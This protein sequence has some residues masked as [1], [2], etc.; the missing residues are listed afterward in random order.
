MAWVSWWGPHGYFDIILA[1]GVEFVKGKGLLTIMGLVPSCLCGSF[2][3]A[4]LLFI[5]TDSFILFVDG[6][7]F[8]FLVSSFPQAYLHE[9]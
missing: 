4:R 1:D 8:S 9:L 5:I 7:I 2:F 6:C 3:F